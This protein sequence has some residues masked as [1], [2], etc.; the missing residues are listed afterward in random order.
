MNGGS[1]KRSSVNLVEGM[2]A[3]PAACGLRRVGEAFE[4]EQGD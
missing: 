3:S 4:G 2:V 1:D